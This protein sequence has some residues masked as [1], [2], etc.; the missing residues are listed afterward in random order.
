MLPR[1][2]LLMLGALG[3]A[4]VQVPARGLTTGQYGA[5]A[6]LRPSLRLRGGGG[7]AP[8]TSVAR[9]GI[10]R[11][12]L[13]A[14]YDVDGTLYDG[15][16]AHCGWWFITSLRD[17]RQRICKVARFCA[18]LP[19]VGLLAAF[20][21]GKAA[22]CLGAVVLQGVSVA[23][24]RAASEHVAEGILRHAYP[25][26]IAHLRTLQRCGHEIVLLSGN[27]EPM[28]TGLGA[29]LRC[30]VVGTVMEQ[31]AGQESPGVDGM[32]TGRVVGDVCV[33]E[34][35]RNRLLQTMHPDHRARGADERTGLVGV[36]N[37][38][39]DIPFLS[40]VQK[41][42]VVRPSSRLGQVAKSQAWDSSSFAAVRGTGVHAGRAVVKKGGG[43]A[44]TARA[45]LRS[46]KA[47]LMCIYGLVC[48][49]VC[50][51]ACVCV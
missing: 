17:P 30:R 40:E 14:Y 13:Q 32:Y 43:A 10:E 1:T 11:P 28:L 50:V 42:F 26:V 44:A 51:C 46:M 20:D 22:A 36:G 5:R 7:G 35:K 16:M 6:L 39:Y 29:H 19:F 45:V 12:L 24:A 37:S 8:G 4:G 38:C 27:V 25:E 34:G 15:T 41:A 2:K 9:L 47:S 48:V 49:C 33:L 21:E 3:V 18:W 23:D 31:H